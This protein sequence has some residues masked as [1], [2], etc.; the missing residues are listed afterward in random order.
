MPRIGIGLGLGLFGG[1]SFA[2]LLDAYPNA[3]VAYSLRLLRS[4]YTG[5]A[6]RVRRSSDNAEQNIG[7]DAL[8]NLNTTALTTFCSGTNGFVTTWYDQSGNGNNLTQSIATN[9]PQIVSSGSVILKN[10]KPT[11]QTDGND[12]FRTSASNIFASTTNLS[13]FSVITDLSNNANNDFIFGVSSGSY[14]VGDANIILRKNSTTFD[15]ISGLGSATSISI[16]RDTNQ[17]ILS[18]LF[19]ASTSVTIRKNGA[20]ATNTTLI[21]SS[22][23][24]TGLLEVESGLGAVL[25]GEW[26]HQELIIYK[27]NQT[28][29]ISQIESN[30][31]SYYNVY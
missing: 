21:P 25:G 19:L 27:S 10:S 13:A 23:N 28:A 7:F 15:F 14:G 12:F 29:N 30:L 2:G 8:G 11:L 9:Q 17:N 22:V 20:S 26:L 18:G 4:A 5:S 1:S 31:N 24:A 16:A 6:V 3:S